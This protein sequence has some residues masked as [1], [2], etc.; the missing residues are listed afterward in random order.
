MRSPS[1]LSLLPALLCLAA[2]AAGQEARPG[3]QGGTFGPGLPDRGPRSG[4]PGGLQAPPAPGQ[5]P[6]ASPPAGG[7]R[8]SRLDTYGVLDE[9]ERPEPPLLRAHVALVGWIECRTSIRADRSGVLGTDLDD[10]ESELGL[11]GAGVAPWVELSVGQEVRGGVDGTWFGRGGDLV[12]Q[13]RRIVLDGRL[14]AEP[15]GYARAQF[16]L[17]SLGTFV[18]WDF[19][20]DATYR[21]GLVGGVRYFRFDLEVKSQVTPSDT[22]FSRVETRGELISPYFGGLVELTPFP[23]LSVLARIEFMNWSWNA[24]E[25]REARY[26][27]LR[28]GFAVHPVPERVSIGAEL[29]YARIRAQGREREGRG[30]SRVDGELGTLGLALVVNV[31][32]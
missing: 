1:R 22:A 15:G 4:G 2:A 7:P 17:L 21:I 9:P 30:G 23:Y 20:Y 29:R 8:D 24:V 6:D 11:D 16:A 10:L 12:R 26:F 28:L 25:L 3:N 19:L 5:P 27:S 31:S 13:E 32:F 18:E 14:V